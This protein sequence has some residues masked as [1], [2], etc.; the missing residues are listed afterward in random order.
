MT[1]FEF[2]QLKNV[3]GFE[4]IQDKAIINVISEDIPY[5]IDVNTSE[6]TCNTQ[7]EYTSNF[8]LTDNFFDSREYNNRC[9]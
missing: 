4:Y 9:K 6:I 5:G 3:S 2:L 1:L 8:K 7:L